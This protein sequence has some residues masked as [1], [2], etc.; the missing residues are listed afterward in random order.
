LSR[1]VG[2]EAAP[3]VGQCVEV[4]F[5]VRRRHDLRREIGIHRLELSVGSD[6][7]GEDRCDLA[8]E[9][10]YFLDGQGAEPLEE[11]LRGDETE[12]FEVLA[13]RGHHRDR[14]LAGNFIK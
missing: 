8:V 7:L 3:V 9:P 10:S 13:E 5:E 12:R 4:E 6:H 11:C 14:A 1:D 2:H